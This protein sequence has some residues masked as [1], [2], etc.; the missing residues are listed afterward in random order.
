MTTPP[1]TDDLTRGLVGLAAGTFVAFV[2]GWGFCLG[3]VWLFLAG[4]QAGM[5]MCGG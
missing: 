5:G 4:V 3:L 2:L 1:D